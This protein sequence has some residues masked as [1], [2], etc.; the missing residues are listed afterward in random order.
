M[1]KVKAISYEMLH[2]NGLNMYRPH[3]TSDYL[4]LFFRTDVE[5]ML[6]SEYIQLEPSTFLLYH[7]DSP[8]FYRKLEGAFNNDWIHFELD[9]AD[10]DFLQNLEIP[11]DTPIRLNE[12]F[13]INRMMEDLSNESFQSGTHHEKLLD[14]KMKALFYKFSDMLQEYKQAP[15][16]V[17][18]HYKRLLQL[19]YQ[20]NQFDYVNTSLNEIADELHMSSSYLSH[21]YKEFFHKS[22]GQDIII[23]RVHYAKLLLNNSEF[24]ITEVANRCGY[25]NIEHFSRQ[26]KKFTG[27]APREYR[28][29]G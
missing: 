26:F 29:L 28:R 14:A 24:S 3:G 22:I 5:V 8:H 20:I 6:D 19:R 16:L 12:C 21:L 27:Y 18:A 25:E 9:E 1:F 11:F 2:P 10:T 13:S 23:S 17:H 7:K 4:F 15:K